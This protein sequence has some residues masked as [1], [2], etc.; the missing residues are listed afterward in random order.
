MNNFFHGIA[1]FITPTL[2]ESQFAEK[3]VLTP[4][5][6]VAAGNLLV[7]KCPTWRWASGEK[8][9]QRSYLPEDKQYLITTNV[10]C[11]KRAT[12]LQ[13]YADA[14]EDVDIEGD[15]DDGGWVSTHVGLDENGFNVVGNGSSSSS[16]SSSNKEDQ[17]DIP[18][19][20]GSDDDDD[21]PEIGGS[22]DDDDDDDIPDMDDFGVE[23]VEDEGA[24]DVDKFTYD[25]RTYDV[26][27]TYDKYYQT[28]RLWLYGYSERG[29]PLTADEMFEDIS[30]DHAKKTAT[31]EQHPHHASSSVSHVSIHPCKHSSVMK[32]IIENMKESGSEFSVEFSLFL[33]LKFVNTIVPTLNYDYTIDVLVK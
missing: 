23:D 33:F 13:D 29:E 14:E 17:D 32:S 21:I 20:G 6:F 24:L 26:S 2:K 12:S 25:T 28:P 4:E 11:E 22:D 16:S 7:Y 18:E 10:P 15:H 31:I 30:Q 1:E 27:I 5:E 19:I 9:K 3:G 8:G